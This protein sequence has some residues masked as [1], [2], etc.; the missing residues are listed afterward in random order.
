MPVRALNLA[1]LQNRWF[2]LTRRFFGR[3]R[4]APAVFHHCG[5]PIYGGSAVLNPFRS[6]KKP[7]AHSSCHNTAALVPER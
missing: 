2:A 5:C 7:T 4:R 6:P 1:S 3:P